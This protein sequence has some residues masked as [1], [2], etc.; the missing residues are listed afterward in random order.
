MRFAPHRSCCFFNLATSLPP[1]RV[2]ICLT[3]LFFLL[4]SGMLSGI[5]AEVFLKGEVLRFNGIVLLPVTIGSA[6]H[7][8]CCYHFLEELM[9]VMSTRPSQRHFRVAPS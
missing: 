4:R 7:L 5:V 8:R 3:T 2:M 6:F 1:K 9:A